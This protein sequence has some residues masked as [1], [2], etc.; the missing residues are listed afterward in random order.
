MTD[1]ALMV[2]IST[3]NNYEPFFGGSSYALE[4]LLRVD[5][6]KEIIEAGAFV[7][8]TAGMTGT[9][10]SLNNIQFIIELKGNIWGFHSDHPIAADHTA[11]LQDLEELA[12]LV[13]RGGLKNKSKITLKL[14][15]GDRKYFGVLKDIMLLDDPDSVDFFTIKFQVLWTV[16]TP[17]WR[18][19]A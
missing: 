7:L 1:N 19:W 15:D 17:T 16:A 6:W 10:L 12:I 5:T 4:I 8:P 9:A 2:S 14:P 11:D 3:E 13:N 18:G